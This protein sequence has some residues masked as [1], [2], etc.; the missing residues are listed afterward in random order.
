MVALKD[1]YTHVREAVAEACLAAGRDPAE[2]QLLAISKYQPSAAIAVVAGLGQ[3]DFGENYV[4]EWQEKRDALSGLL[5]GMGLRW[6]MTGH[7]QHRKASLVAGTFA[8]L[9]TLDSQKLAHALETHLVARNLLQPVLLEVNLGDERQKAGVS[10]DDALALAGYVLLHCPHLQLQGLMCIPPANA[11]ASRPFFA[12]LR[13]LRDRMER[14]LGVKLSELSM[15]M[16][17]DFAEA[18]AEGATI[19]RIGTNIFGPRP[20]KKA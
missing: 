20:E 11:R 9:H 5:P 15:G 10:T 8:L 4:Q 14:E 16:S 3:R 6:H 19:V 17:H 13:Q 1:N 7:I 18:I 2:V 12:E